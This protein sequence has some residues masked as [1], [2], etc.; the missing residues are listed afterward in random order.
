M[1]ATNKAIINMSADIEAFRFNQGGAQLYTLANAISDLRDESESAAAARR[2]G[3][4][5]LT[6]LLPMAH[7]YRRGNVGATRPYSDA[8]IPAVAGSQYQPRYR[9]SG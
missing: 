1:R 5:T 4:E 6:K 3:I 7:A 2:F 9:R 8:G